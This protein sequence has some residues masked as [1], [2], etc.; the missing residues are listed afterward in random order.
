MSVKKKLADRIGLAIAPTLVKTILGTIFLTSR[1]KVIGEEH[2]DELGRITGHKCR[3]R[4][5][6]PQSIFHSFRRQNSISRI[7][8]DGSSA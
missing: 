5:T 8:I 7:G 6:S 4:P 3:E 1:I 2:L